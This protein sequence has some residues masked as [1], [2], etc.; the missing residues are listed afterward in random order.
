MMASLLV[1]DGKLSLSK[2]EATTPGLRIGVNGAL[3]YGHSAFL[4]FTCIKQ[5]SWKE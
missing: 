1:V 5:A 2:A 4:T 3:Q